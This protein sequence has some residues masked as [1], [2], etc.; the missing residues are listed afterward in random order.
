MTSPPWFPL[1]SQDFVHSCRTGRMTADEV[2]ALIMVMCQQWEKMGVLVSDPARF[3]AYAGWDIRVAKRL[4]AR[5][6]EIDK[7]KATERGIE[8]ARMS[9][10]ISKYIA[11]VRG[12]EAR[13]ARRRAESENQFADEKRRISS[14]HAP[15][16]S[17]KFETSSPELSRKDNQINKP[18]SRAA[19]LLESKLDTD[20]KSARPS[21][22]LEKANRKVQA[23]SA[24]EQFN[25]FARQHGWSVVSEFSDK[26]LADTAKRLDEI[27][28]LDRFVLALNQVPYDDFLMGRIPGRNGRKPFRLCLETLLSTGS[29]LGDVLA[30]LIDKASETPELIGPNGERWGFWRPDIEKLKTLSAAFWR[31][32]LDD[33]KSNGTWPWWLLG[34]P[35]GHEECFVHP[36]IITELGLADKYRDT[37]AKVSVSTTAN[38]RPPHDQLG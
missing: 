18:S 21:L 35:P 24:I 20:S 38:P 32:R 26:R 37:A 36:D 27:G 10:E 9:Q 3:A 2:G 33:V 7:I 34:P 19:P 12:A 30:R 5:L 16:F 13:E 8:N 29:G 14:E 1:Y 31:K 22:V 25:H 6:I 15:N 4:L 11:K 28:G 23:R 17:K